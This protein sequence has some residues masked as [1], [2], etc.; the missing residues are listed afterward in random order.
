MM[1]DEICCCVAAFLSDEIVIAENLLLRFEIV[2]VLLR[3]CQKLT[4]EINF[5]KWTMAV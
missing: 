4:V 3:L 5:W 2:T 1:T